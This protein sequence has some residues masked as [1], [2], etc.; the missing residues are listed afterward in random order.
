MQK[1]KNDIPSEYQ[2]LP[3]DSITPEYP[4]LPDE[5]LQQDRLVWNGKQE[6]KERQKNQKR[7]AMRMVSMLAACVLLGYSAYGAEAGQTKMPAQ[8]TEEVPAPDENGENRDGREND[9]V[10]SATTEPETDDAIA[11]TSEPVEEQ[12]PLEGGTL[13]YKI[14]NET[15]LANPT[16]DA[17]E[18]ILEEGEI[19][20]EQLL[21]G[22]V[23]ALPQPETP[24]GFAFLGWAAYFSGE[25]DTYP[26]WSLLTESF[27]AEDAARIKPDEEGNR[28]V[29]IHAV[30]NS[31]D[32]AAWQMIMVLDANGGTIAGQPSQTYNAL[33]PKYSGGTVYLCGYPTPERE[34]YHFAGW[35]LT[36]D[37]G[38][39]LV[40]TLPA[41]RFFAQ[42]NGEPDYNAPLELHLMAGW[43]KSEEKGN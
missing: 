6:Q 33:T 43:E 11:E 32:P 3:P 14:Y 31:Q 38:D 20:I 42:Q 27:T 35:Y 10:Q 16:A 24:E 29:D 36:T 12:Y 2:T 18:R 13:Y 30:W 22:E 37:E 1:Y 39:I 41:S 17:W 7:K 9:L 34:G 28:S 15:D 4:P 8:T 21:A 40:E 23:I 5:Y 25:K 19:T 26:K